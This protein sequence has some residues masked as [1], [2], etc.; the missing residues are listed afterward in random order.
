M[1]GTRDKAEFLT[2]DWALA[3]A[4]YDRFADKLDTIGRGTQ[5][6]VRITLD[7]GSPVAQP[8]PAGTPRSPAQRARDGDGAVVP[9]TAPQ[10]ARGGVARTSFW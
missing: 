10:P 5:H 4:A 2:A 8:D 9:A 1:W 6:T 7:N 3:A